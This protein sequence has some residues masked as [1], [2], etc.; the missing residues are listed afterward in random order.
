M[1]RCKPASKAASN[2]AVKQRVTQLATLRYLRAAVLGAKQPTRL[3]RKPEGRLPQASGS[4]TQVRR[5]PRVCCQPV[6]RAVREDA[7]VAE[8]RARRTA[9]DLSVSRG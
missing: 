7:A 2:A 4:V 5:L 1:L 8:G 3:T 9:G 6:G